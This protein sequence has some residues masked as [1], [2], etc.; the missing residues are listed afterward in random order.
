[1]NHLIAECNNFIKNCGLT[2]AFCGGHAL[3]MFTCAKKR[4]HS[5]VDITLFTED[6]KAIID[7]ILN[8]GWITN[9]KTS[10][11][12]ILFSI[13]EMTKNLYN[14]NYS[15]LPN[16]FSGHCGCVENKKAS[17]NINCGHINPS[18]V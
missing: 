1:M 5:D 7:F 10:I 9:R 12:L 14:K 15:I 16:S 3:E 17:R 13:K 8:K 6:R 4:A 18:R 2:Y 11:L